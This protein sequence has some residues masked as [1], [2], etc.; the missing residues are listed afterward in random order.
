MFLSE[1]LMFLFKTLTIVGSIIFIIIV[2][3]YIKAR[4][5]KSKDYGLLIVKDLSRHYYELK[6]QM[7]KT[8]SSKHKIKDTVKEFKKVL[9][10]KKQKE[11]EQN[12]YVIKFKGNIKATA[13]ESLKEEITAI[14][15]IAHKR[16][17]VVIILESPGGTVSG[18]GL[19]ASELNRIKNKG[20]KLIVIVDKVAASGGYMMASIA[21]QIIA[22]PFAII[23]SV[24]VASQIPNFN[25]LLKDKGIEY[26]Q[27]TSGK[28]KRTVTMFG[29]NTDEGR[30][31]LQLELEEIHSQ[32]KSLIKKQRPNIDIE[33]ISIG[34]YWLAEKAKELKLVDDLMTS[35][36]YLMDLNESG[37]NIYQIEYKKE[38]SLMNKLSVACNNIKSI[39]Q[40]KYD[41]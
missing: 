41:I 19:A 22:A 4:I 17:K 38:L 34:E 32:F 28:Y 36:E 5:R 15:S 27:I 16:D 12:I 3:F 21:S 6:L 35:D 8:I 23:G 24:G 29:K 20:I 9:K 1:Y 14:L 33:K 31:K 30:Q 10:G 13:V 11:N 39:F 25:Q 26:E 7:L 18:Y 40:T 37:N 2:Y